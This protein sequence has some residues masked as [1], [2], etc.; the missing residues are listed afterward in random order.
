MSNLHSSLIY[1][2]TPRT[3]GPDCGNTF[4]TTAQQATEGEEPIRPKGPNWLA[5]AI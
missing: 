3:V 2:I 1:Q 4:A 5:E